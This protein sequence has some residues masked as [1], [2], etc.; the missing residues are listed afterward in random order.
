MNRWKLYLVIPWSVRPPFDPKL[1]LEYNIPVKQS[2]S[3]VPRP[4][5]C[6]FCLFFFSSSLWRGRS[7]PWTRSQ[8]KS[9]RT[10]VS[11][12]LMLR[13]T[14]LAACLVWTPCG[15]RG[16]LVEA[17]NY[18]RRTQ[19]LNLSAENHKWGSDTGHEC[20]SEQWNIQLDLRPEKTGW[21]LLLLRV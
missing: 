17:K 3:A 18:R 4:T 12:G 9:R 10:A 13:I 20:I 8:S 14:T 5:P 21:Y 2:R 1:A 16:C 6:L 19:S 7:P 15:S 11:I